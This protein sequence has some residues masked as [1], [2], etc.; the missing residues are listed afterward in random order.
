M[1]ENNNSNDLNDE[2]VVVVSDAD[3]ITVPIDDTLS[4]SG[5]AADAK[6]VGD[7]LA[8]KADASSVTAI[9]V[10]GQT[11]DNQGVIIVTGSDTAVSDDDDTKI[12]SKISAL[13]AKTAED[14]PMS[15][16]EGAQSIAEAIEDG[17]GR[18]ADEIAMSDED[19]TTVKSAIDTLSGT[20]GTQGTAIAA[21]QVQTAADIKYQS[22]S[23]ETVKAHVDALAE[24]IVRSVNGEEP[25]ADGDVEIQTVPYAQNLES[26]S[27][28]RN[29][30][31]FIQ[32][33]SGGD[34]TVDSGEAWLMDVQ[35]NSVHTGYTAESITM[36]VN[37]DSISAT[38][39]RDTF[40]EEVTASGTTTLSYTTSWSADP[41]TYGVTVTGT[42]TNGDSI[43]IVYVK[44]VRGTITVAEPDSFVSTGWNLYNNTDGYAKVVKYAYG[45]RISGSWTALKYSATLTGTKT[46][47]TV[48]DGAFNVAADGFVWVT[49]GDSDTAIWATWEDW[50]EAYDGNF[51]AYSKTEVDLS[52]IM[53]TYFP[54]GLCAVGSVRDEINLNLGVAI[55]RVEVL[56]YNATNLATAKNSGRDYEYDE[57]FI[58]LVRAS[59][60]SSSVTI[61][62]AF[63]T[64]DH[65]I[66]YFT[67]TGL[68]VVTEV[69]YGNNLKNKLERDTLTIS[70]QS[71]TDAQ[72][73]QVQ[74]NI[75]VYSK[76][77]GKAEVVYLDSSAT[78]AKIYS[79]FSGLENYKTATFSASVNA[80][81]LI[82]S[83]K[84]TSRSLSGT[85]RKNDSNYEIMGR[86]GDDGFVVI[87]VSNPSSSSIGTV[88]VTEMMP[89]NRMLVGSISANGSITINIAN[90]ARGMLY[91]AGGNSSRSGLY[92]ISASS[93]G[94]PAAVALVTA[95]ALTITTTTNNKIVVASSGALSYCV[96][97]FLTTADAITI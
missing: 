29:Y 41:A 8:L 44:E 36:T 24:G 33:T 60:T 61:D 93:N 26:E 49:G 83:N 77:N 58:Y 19:E 57:N 30:G 89:K 42:P 34:G 71:L 21:L 84:I 92:A 20:V 12:A 16:E 27:T 59:E 79:A 73:T 85:I 90:N 3:V 69:L 14:I 56:A 32:R 48:N 37:G 11:A 51:A 94:E 76:I 18:T 64:N 53:E 10:N 7:A 23:T 28:H 45:F 68:A 96:I 70:Q 5:E 86:F 47:I 95:S 97:P 91:V 6:A 17:I 78:V 81:K 82:T 31:T 35:G 1:S 25:D 74:T 75:G 2:V 13:D 52:G 22:G 63:T 80:T 15:S 67:G 9:S 55:S 46:D 39:D 50:T 62:G 38:I 88:T 72:K 43:V 40:V 87:K 4:N 66:E 54:Y 65:G